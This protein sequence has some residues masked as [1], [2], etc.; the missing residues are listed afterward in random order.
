[1]DLLGL[2]IF[3]AARCLIYF[4]F[5]LKKEGAKYIADYSVHLILS[6]AFI[7]FVGEILYQMG[8]Y[9]RVSWKYFNWSLPFIPLVGIT[10]YELIQVDIFRKI[11]LPMCM[12]CKYLRYLLVIELFWLAFTG[13]LEFIAGT[14][15]VCFASFLMVILEKAEKLKKKLEEMVDKVCSLDKQKNDQDENVIQQILC[16][17]INIFV[18]T[19]KYKIEV[20]IVIGILLAATLSEI[21][22]S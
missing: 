14:V 15:A 19:Y 8:Y 21:R 2:S 3:M 5:K 17:G 12:T 11:V 20:P 16:K 13:Y 9:P 22:L 1:M 6:V 10:V 4:T 7:C 18:Y